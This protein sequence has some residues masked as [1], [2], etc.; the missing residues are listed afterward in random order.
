MRLFPKLS[1]FILVKGFD[2]ISKIKLLKFEGDRGDLQKSNHVETIIKKIS[3]KKY[4]NQANLRGTENFRNC[5]CVIFSYYYK[6]TI[7][8]NEDWELDS[9]F[10][11]L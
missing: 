2:F 8:S 7:L 6:S 10:T 3:G 1:H 4:R 5:L 9:F 11:E